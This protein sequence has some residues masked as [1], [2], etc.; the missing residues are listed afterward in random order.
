MKRQLLMLAFLAMIVGSANLVRPQTQNAGPKS[1]VEFSADPAATSFLLQHRRELNLSPEQ[2]KNLLTLRSDFLK[3]ALK[4]RADLQVIEL[5]VTELRAMT[6]PDLTAIAEKIK[7]A[8]GIKTQLR[9]EDVKADENAKARLTRDQRQKLDDRLEQ[10]TRVTSPQSPP[11][12]D[13]QQQIRTVL[14]EKYKDQKVV[15]L[16][17]SEAIMARLI[18]WAKTFGIFV[19]VPLTILGAVL[20]LFGIKSVSDVSTLADTGRKDI[21]QSVTDAKD[22][23]LSLLGTG[24]D[25][26][27]KAFTAA[28]AKA[29]AIKNKGETLVAEYRILEK[30]FAEVA[31]LAQEVP[32]LARNLSKLT[33]KVESIEEK[34]TVESSSTPLAK[35]KRLI[36][37]F[38]EFQTYFKKLGFIAPKGE[39]KIKIDDQLKLNSFYEPESNRVRVSPALVDDFEFTLHQYVH[40]ALS[41]VNTPASSKIGAIGEALAD[42]FTCSFTD[43]PLVGEGSIH[44]F[45][46]AFGKD[47]FPNNCLR[48]LKNSRSFKEVDPKLPETTE[49]HA[50]GEI[51][52]GAFWEIRG[53]I[54]QELADKLLFATWGVLDVSDLHGKSGTKFV[55]KLLEQ[56]EQFGDGSKGKQI[57]DIFKRRDLDL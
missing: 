12:A 13:L 32:A 2:V 3:Q 26:I 15:E 54:G 37:K 8:E 4:Q 11:D 30:Q 36:A 46:E 18:D 35:K 41:A 56:Y 9:I 31:V 16:E 34:I 22:E 43:D 10:I 7:Q 17:T 1:S 20:G 29:E 45:Q 24:K 38:K 33:S 28:Q 50:V 21:S 49:L 52:G 55:N 27:E 44:L 53:L 51:W 14:D 23:I 40:H 19:G 6:P 47:R 25:S 57:A 39:V 42:Y 5:E 48:N